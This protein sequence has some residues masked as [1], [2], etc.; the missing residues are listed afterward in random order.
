MKRPVSWISQ[1]WASS[2]S[3]NL[4]DSNSMALCVINDVDASTSIRKVQYN[5]RRVIVELALVIRP[6]TVDE[7][8]TG[9]YAFQIPWLLGIAD[10]EDQDMENVTVAG[11]GTWLQSARILRCGMQA[12][13]YRQSVS[14]SEGFH[15]GSLVV[16]PNISIDWKGRAKMG[17][18]DILW[19][20]L[21]T[22]NDGSV[23]NDKVDNDLAAFV[24][25]Y[26]RTLISLR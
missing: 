12:F 7:D 15:D 8:L 9:A 14:G 26:S 22:E 16:L 10:A 23:A 19:L 5:L 24:N 25:G 13:S 11:L 6:K 18:D 2:I 20:V 21:N 4:I 3:L 17:P 1:Y